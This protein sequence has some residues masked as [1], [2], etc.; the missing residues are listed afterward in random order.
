MRS[1]IHRGSRIGEIATFWAIIVLCSL[2]LSGLAF[3]AA[4]Y[5]VGGLM[6]RSKATQSS[7]QLVLKTPAEQQQDEGANLGPERVDPPSQ[8]VVKMQPRAPTDGEKSEVEQMYPQDAAGLHASGDQSKGD[9]STGSDDKPLDKT[10]TTDAAPAAA[11]EQYSVVASSFRDEANARREAEKLGVRG[12]DARVVDVTR[13]GQTFHR[14][15][16]GS[17]EDRTEAEH[18]CDRLKGEGTAATIVTR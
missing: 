16:V 3:V 14:V 10:G 13:D 2:L 11:G 15:V 7:P 9:D 17:F 6:A 12:Y 5:W 4:K 8:A 18:M 1:R